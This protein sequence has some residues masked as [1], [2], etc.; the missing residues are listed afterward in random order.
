LKIKRRRKP[1]MKKLKKCLKSEALQVVQMLT[2]FNLPRIQ[3]EKLKRE[4]PKTVVEMDQMEA[5][6]VETSQ[7]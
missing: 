4:R 3:A 7:A 6:L 1:K 5:D 2:N